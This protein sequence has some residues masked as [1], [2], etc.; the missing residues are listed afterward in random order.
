[1]DEDWMRPR[2]LHPVLIQS[3]HLHGTALPIAN[4]ALHSPPQCTAETVAPPTLTLQHYNAT[5]DRRR[6][7]PLPETVAPPAA[8]ALS[9]ADEAAQIVAAA[10][11]AQ[12]ERVKASPVTQKLSHSDLKQS[13]REIVREKKEPSKQR[14]ERKKCGVKFVEN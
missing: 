4:S 14:A 8:P 12:E 13:L 11:A 3:R 10:K 9:T 6:S 2:S 5:T 1:M 7:P